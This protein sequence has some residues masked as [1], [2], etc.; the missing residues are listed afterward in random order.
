MIGA[1][2]GNILDQRETV[3]IGS[4]SSRELA[5]FSPAF[6]EFTTSGFILW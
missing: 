4:H 1:D 3:T 2:S 5:N 6:A